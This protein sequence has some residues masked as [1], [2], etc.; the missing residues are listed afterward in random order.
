MLNFP[1]TPTLNQEYTFGNKSWKFNGTAWDLLSVSSA[2]V[3]AAEASAVSANAS[4]REFARAYLG[5]K[6]SDPTLDN[7]GNALAEGAVY[8]NTG[9]DALKYYNGSAWVANPSSGAISPVTVAALPSAA[10]IGAGGK[11]F[12][13]DASA[14][15]FASVVAGGGANN[16][17]VYSDGTNWRIG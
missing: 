9:T 14:T 15:T 4:R 17:P 2:Q 12:V 11:A 5:A 3:A 6:A 16:V 7:E 10:T 13:S 8:W 1:N